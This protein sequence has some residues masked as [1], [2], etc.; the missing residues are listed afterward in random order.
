MEFGWVNPDPPV[1]IIIDYDT[2]DRT[3]HFTNEAD[4]IQDDSDNLLTS[5]AYVLKIGN[6]LPTQAGGDFTMATVSSKYYT[7]MRGNVTKMRSGG[8]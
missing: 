7:S 3:A 8:W 5:N 1:E 2:A 6:Y 4:E